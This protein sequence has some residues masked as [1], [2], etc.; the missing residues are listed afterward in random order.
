VGKRSSSR[1]L[2]MQLLYKSEFHLGLGMDEIAKDVFERSQNEPETKAFAM[3][4]ATIAK[5]HITEIDSL[6]ET[7]STDWDLDRL[8][9]VDKSIMR[10]AFSEIVYMQ[11][12]PA[13]AID[14]ALRLAKKFSSEDSPK[15]ING[16]LGAY[17]KN[18]CSLES[19]KKSDK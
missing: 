15:F 1:K 14:E 16:I 3:E 17:V 6:I 9:Q 19:S 5:S 13:V 18:Q 2:A 10:L 7:Y 11:T 8:N 4:M 12:P